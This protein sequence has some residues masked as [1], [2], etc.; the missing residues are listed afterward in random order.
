MTAEAYAENKENLPIRKRGRVDMLE[1]I[2]DAGTDN[3]RYTDLHV[4]ESG[5]SRLLG[6]CPPHPG[7]QDQRR[8]Y[9]GFQDAQQAADNH[10][11]GVGLRGRMQTDQDTPKCDVHTEVDAYGKSLHEV[12]MG[13]FWRKLAVVTYPIID[14]DHDRVYQ[15]I[16]RTCDDVPDVKTSACQSGLLA[17]GVVFS[18]CSEIVVLIALEVVLDSHD[19]R[20]VEQCLVEVLQEVDG[21]EKRHDS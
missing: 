7:D 6:F 21:H 1:A 13:K 10:Q 15:V 20:I 19:R 4:P 18:H 17:V 5:A 3:L 2:G 8:S 9:G 14:F 11:T 12:G 16:E